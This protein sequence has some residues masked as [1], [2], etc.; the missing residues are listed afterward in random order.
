[1][2]IEVLFVHGAGEGAH[3]EDSRMAADLQ[4]R[5]GDGYR[6]H[7]PQLPEA[8]PA[9]ASWQSVIAEQLDALGAGSVVVG[10]S[11]GASVVLKHIAQEQPDVAGLYLVATPWWGEQDWDASEFALPD[12]FADRLDRDCPLVLYHSRDDE[13]VPF[14][15]QARYAAA[16]PWATVRTFD[17]RGHQLRDDLSEVADDIRASG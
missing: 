13:W 11:F 14:A 16:M 9:F 8:A 15:H 10:H 12:D 6:V 17:D 2:A 5:L 7:V 1:M 3:E 4:R